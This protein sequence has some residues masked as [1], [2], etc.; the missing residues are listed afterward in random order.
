MFFSGIQRFTLL[1]YPGRVACILFSPGCNMRCGFCHNMEFVL[2]E[3]IKKLRGTF[4]GEDA[5]YSFLQKRVGKLEAVVFFGF[6]PTQWPDI[7]CIMERVKNL[8]FLVKIDTNGSH[9][10]I[11]RRILQKGI[12]DA[13][14]LDIKT[15]FDSYASLTG[16]DCGKSVC[17]S[18]EI[19]TGSGVWYECRTTLIDEVHTNEILSF[20]LRDLSGV[21]RYALQTFRPAHTLSSSFGSFHAFSSLRMNSFASACRN[22]IPEVILR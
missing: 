9:P 6:E 11:L 22:I 3:K 13:V 16:L 18:L 14:A 20:L 7:V 2:P 12:V 15:S 4:I 8:G 1:D 19:L 17:E 5:V 10:E 21:R